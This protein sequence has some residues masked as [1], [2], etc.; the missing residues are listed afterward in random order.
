[1]RRAVRWRTGALLVLVVG[2]GI[3][4]AVPAAAAEDDLRIAGGP[5]SA[6]DATP[7][8]LDARIHLP[9]RLPAPAVVL[10]H[11]F[12][13]SKDAVAA[14]AELL[15]DRGFVVLAYSARGFGASTGLISMNSPEF[16]VAD[17]ARI[18][19]Y[20]AE[21]PEVVAD[22]PGDPRVGI[23]GGSYGG[24]LAL[25]AAGYDDRVD[26]VAA[27]ITWNDLQG[28]L[29]GQS[30]QPSA[31]GAAVSTGVYKQL[32]S[33]LFFSAGLT[34]VDG[35]VTTCGR[36][37][38]QW[39]DA[40]TEA[41]TTG[42]LS[43]EAAELMRRSSPG[44]ITDR[45]SVP[46]LLGGGQADSLFPLAQVNATAEQIARA[47]PDTPLKV[48]WHAAGHDG[49]VDETERLRT[50]T[51]DWFDAHLA[52][53]PAVPTTFEMSLVE[54][55]ALSDRA[56]GTVQ[57]LT[58][59][60]YPG[61]SGTG[62]TTYPLAGP[63]Q[64]VLAPAGGVPA[65]ITSLPGVGGLAALASS[66]VA[67]PLPN[68]SATF[69]T[70]PLPGPQQ[71]A[72]SPT[73]RIAVSAD[74]EVTDVTLFTS[75]RTV[76]TQDRQVLPN[77]LVAPIRLER[78][79][80]EPTVIDVQLP[81]IV[82]EAAAG[83]RLALVVSTTDQAFRM[84]AGPA[85]YT[86]ALAEPSVVV[87]SVAATAAA[88]GLPAWAWPLGGVAVAV[89]AWLVV[90]LL[91]PRY[92]GVQ[93]RPDLAEYPVVVEGLVKQFPGGVTAVDGVGFTVPPGVVLGLLGPNGAGKST[94]MRMVM[95]LIAPTAGEARV[96]GQQ[97]HPGSAA[98]ARVGCFVEGPGLLP[99]LTGR[100]NLDLFWRASG[101]TGI[102]PRFDEVLEIAGLGGAIDRR[103][104]TY[105][106]GMRQRLGIAQAMLGLPDLLLLDEPTNGLDPPQIKEM[107]QVVQDYAR[108]G[109]TVI[110]SSHLLSEVEQTC[111]H[112]V[113][114]SRG[115]VIA[116]GTV[117]DLLAGHGG[118]RLEDV[119]L[120][121]VGEGHTVVTS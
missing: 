45:I 96:F 14:E 40:Y 85:V 75:L 27:D 23:A 18:V 108:D 47:N 25:L 4:A 33:G 29:F 30:V 88:A 3:G 101:R 7:V 44:S 69:V 41:A 31:E 48:V 24:A 93:H 95:G 70:E 15:T 68:Q 59:P 49:G 5:S 21:R 74:A 78:V 99:H 102:D 11:G 113:V 32:W 97:V 6:D 65:A 103:V 13:G 79:G 63:P 26:A 86:I 17:A 43:A 114:M 36:F 81:A 58:A 84:P 1:M 52:D 91:R 35:T 73:V 22:A 19:D 112:V 80:P 38:P 42:T 89:L 62:S 2:A 118:R 50:L 98:L 64:Q 66:L 117:A 76:G 107:R 120:E 55:S 105:S 119:F 10:A 8:S 109:R 90:T 46:T 82:T 87:P 16:E 67:V 116:S 115:R 61:I 121:M 104:R 9:D 53:G 83:D 77:G 72:G 20:L 57:V 92:R 60:A 39:C 100:Q 34:S 106:Q 111:S 51:A 37:A 56:R 110:V 71:I 94:T 12:G 28:S 54:G